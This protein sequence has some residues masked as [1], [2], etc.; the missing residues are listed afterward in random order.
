GREIVGCVFLGDLDLRIRL[1]ADQTF[2]GGAIRPV[3]LQPQAPLDRR[4]DVLEWNDSAARDLAGIAA[5]PMVVVEF[6]VPDT[7]RNV[8]YARLA[9]IRR[10]DRPQ[11]AGHRLELLFGDLV[12]QEIGRWVGLFFEGVK[13][14]GEFLRHAVQQDRRLSC[15]VGREE[16]QWQRKHNLAG[17]VT[18]ITSEETARPT[19]SH[20]CYPSAP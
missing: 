1:N 12:A 5:H 10:I 8:E 7:D 9:A 17:Q 18:R 11:R 14:S 16:Q 20:A 2:R 13:V 19:G 3:G 4:Y 15:S 6:L